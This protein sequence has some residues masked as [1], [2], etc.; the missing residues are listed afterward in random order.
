[1]L[2]VAIF[3]TT[4]YTYQ[5]EMSWTFDKNIV[6]IIAITIRTFKSIVCKAKLGRLYKFH[7]L[8]QLFHYKLC[9]HDQNHN[10]YILTKKEKKHVF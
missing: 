8:H 4:A 7:F 9:K 10:E 5:V 2:K 6:Y 3:S 1:M